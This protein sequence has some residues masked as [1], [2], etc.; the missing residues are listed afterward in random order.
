MYAHIWPPLPEA[1]TCI[2]ICM[3]QHQAESSSSQQAQGV[4]KLS[5]KESYPH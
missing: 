5:R 4:L 2:C 1:R 3:H